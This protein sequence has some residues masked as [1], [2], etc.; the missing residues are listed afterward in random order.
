MLR[1]GDFGGFS[2]WSRS[3][4]SDFVAENGKKTVINDDMVGPEFNWN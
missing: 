2:Q 3:G 4:K 1:N